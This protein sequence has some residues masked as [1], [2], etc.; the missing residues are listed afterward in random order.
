MFKF[1]LK[2][3]STWIVDTFNVFYKWIPVQD[4]AVEALNLNP[5]GRETVFHLSISLITDRSSFKSQTLTI[6]NLLES[7]RNSYVERYFLQTIFI[8]SLKYNLLSRNL[9]SCFTMRKFS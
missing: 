7:L 1:L 3:S 4:L 6:S 8:T 2:N 5:S 9:R